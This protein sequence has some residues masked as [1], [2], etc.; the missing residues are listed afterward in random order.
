[1]NHSEHCKCQLNLSHTT[2]CNFMLQLY[3]ITMLRNSEV[4]HISVN[5][6]F[7]VVPKFGCTKEQNI[8]YLKKICLVHCFF[9]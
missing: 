3:L 8:E 1:M 5:S 6:T 4:L 2:N 7:R 9:N